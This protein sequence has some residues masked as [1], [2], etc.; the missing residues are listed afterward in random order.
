MAEPGLGTGTGTDPRSPLPLLELSVRAFSSMLLLRAALYVSVC[1]RLNADFKVVKVTPTHFS[2]PAP[3]P[4]MTHGTPLSRFAGKSSRPATQLS[5]SLLGTSNREKVQTES[6]CARCMR[7]FTAA[8]ATPAIC[9][10]YLLNSAWWACFGILLMIWSMNK[11][12]YFSWPTVAYCTSSMWNINPYC[13]N[14]GIGD[15]RVL[16]SIVYST[17]TTYSSIPMWLPIGFACFPAAIVYLLAA[18]GEGFVDTEHYNAPLATDDCKDDVR[19][20]KVQAKNAPKC[21]VPKNEYSH[22]ILFFARFFSLPITSAM[23]CVSVSDKSAATA[24]ASM[25][26]TLL[27]V[28]VSYVASGLYAWMWVDPTLKVKADAIGTQRVEVPSVWSVIPMQQLAGLLFLLWVVAT[29]G[30]MYPVCM[31]YSLVPAESVPV[32]IRCAF[33]M[34]L[35]HLSVMT[36][37]FMYDLLATYMSAS[38]KNFDVSA[39]VQTY[40]LWMVL[41]HTTSSACGGLFLLFSYQAI[42]TANYTAL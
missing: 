3:L 13:T 28:W 21:D 11:R 39:S 17:A 29:F 16:S 32:W 30:L 10:F 5:D 14:T 41:M 25:S 38:R 36:L 8:T 2:S 23:L 7:G 12:M 37:H 22:A 4:T 40:T 33:G 9:V 31:A 6:G 34:Y 26:A 24:L 27:L 19:P 18:M 35:A 15:S 42:S 20:I 1:A